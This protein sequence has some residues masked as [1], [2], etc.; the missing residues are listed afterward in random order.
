[1][2]DCSCPSSYGLIK[3]EYTVLSALA[4]QN[5]LQKAD[6]CFTNEDKHVV[7]F[8]TQMSVDCGI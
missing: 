7:S 6:K 3:L 2:I 8:A 5:A 4:A 1:M